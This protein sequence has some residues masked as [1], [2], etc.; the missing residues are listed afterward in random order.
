[1]FNTQ[2]AKSTSEK[3]SKNILGKDSNKGFDPMNMNFWD[4]PKKQENSATK[5]FQIDGGRNFDD[6]LPDDPVLAKR[7]KEAQDKKLAELHALQ[8]KERHESNV[9]KAAQAHVKNKA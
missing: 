8:D 7:V 6:A 5:G 3:P 1:M 4:S 9:R 2:S